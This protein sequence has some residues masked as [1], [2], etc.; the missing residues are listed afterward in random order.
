MRLPKFLSYVLFA[1]YAFLYI[2]IITLVVY[3]FNESELL[4]V[5][6][7]FSTRWYSALLQNELILSAA[8][9][10]IKIAAVSATGAV[11]FGTIASLAL[12]RIKRF[13]GKTLFVGLLFSPMVMP[14][15]ITGLAFLLFFV[16]AQQFTG[17]PSERGFNTITIAHITITVAYATLIIRTRLMGVQKDLHEAAQ[18]LGAHPIKVFFVITLPLII[19][20]LVTAWLLAFIISL[21]DLVIASF[22]SG[23]GATTLPMAIYSSIRL[24]ITPEINAL[25]T[26]LITIVTMGVTI[27]GYF[28]Y[29]RERI[30]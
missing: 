3:S 28:L 22:V 17:W 9:L 23:P 13:R 20:A 18:D 2:P 16:A 24:G 27:T 19:P 5:W 29:R 25:A 7:G 11:L 30:Q 21:D 26:I 14:E 6:G 4:T 8:W 10:S 12:V 1:G 15:V